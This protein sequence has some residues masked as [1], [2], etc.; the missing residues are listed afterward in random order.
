M[1]NSSLIN[2]G[3]LAK[4]VKTLIVKVS[5]A[6]GTLYEPR[7]I[8][9]AADAEADAAITKAQNEI[10]ITD[11]QRRAAQRRIEEDTLH[12]KHIE[13]IIAKAIPHVDENASPENMDDEWIANLF[14]KCRIVSDEKMQSLWARVLATEAN[15]PG[16]FSKRTVNLLS[17]F[18]KSDAKLFTKFCGFCWEIA[19]ITPLVF[20]FN[21]EI[22]K[23]HGINVDTVI[24]LETMGLIQF[25]TFE[26]FEEDAPPKDVYY[27]GKRLTLE[28]PE[29][30][31][32]ALNIG[33]ILL[34]KSGQELFPICGSTPVGG[35]YEYVKGQWKDYLPA[36]ERVMGV[37]N[38][39]TATGL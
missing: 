32:P 14:E 31:N 2:L 20:D 13:D 19:T 35:F 7:R 4:P 37:E 25:E 10:E 34:T 30:P 22:Y 5:D 23:K 15:T 38:S 26:G 6:V 28:I 11:L 21:A 9:N 17:D 18:D 12:Q 16:T 29:G 3:D 36:D 24:H 1:S 8:R 27:Y 33:Y 39:G